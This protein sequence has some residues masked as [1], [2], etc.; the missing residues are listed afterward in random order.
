MKSS[1]ALFWSKRH[2]EG[3]QPLPNSLSLKTHTNKKFEIAI[4]FSIVNK[5][6][7]YVSGDVGDINPP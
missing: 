2:W 7:N 5:S 6:N 1:S 3:K 4:L